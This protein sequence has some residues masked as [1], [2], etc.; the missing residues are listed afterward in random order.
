MLPAL[1]VKL[2]T[3]PTCGASFSFEPGGFWNVCFGFRLGRVQIGIKCLRFRGWTT[4]VCERLDANDANVFALWEGQN[5][6]HLHGR[7]RL[8]QL[9]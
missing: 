5:I 8:G 9:T 2:A 1:K 7:G 3:I 6:A 4:A